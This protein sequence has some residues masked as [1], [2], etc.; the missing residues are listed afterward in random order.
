MLWQF[1]LFALVTFLTHVV[2]PLATASCMSLF[3][4]VCVSSKQMMTRRRTSRGRMLSTWKSSCS[5]T[6]SL[7]AGRRWKISLTGW[8]VHPPALKAIVGCPIPAWSKSAWHTI[9]LSCGLETCCCSWL[10]YHMWSFTIVC[11]QKYITRLPVLSPCWQNHIP[12][13][14]GI[15]R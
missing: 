5:S 3:F 4:H 2:L 12:L 8:I 13:S 15:E 6:R 9:W 10:H 11:K 14:P 7:P 1:A